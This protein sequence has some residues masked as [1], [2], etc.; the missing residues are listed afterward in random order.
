MFLFTLNSTIKNQAVAHR[1]IAVLAGEKQ[2][3]FGQGDWRSSV[4]QHQPLKEDLGC[5]GFSSTVRALGEKGFLIDLFYPP[6][7]GLMPF[8][9]VLTSQVLCIYTRS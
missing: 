6:R 7:P 1:I 4:G 5:F 2:N 3:R 9:A 8:E